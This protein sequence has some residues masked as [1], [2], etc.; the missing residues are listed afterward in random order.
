MLPLFY[1]VRRKYRRL[2]LRLLTYMESL[3]PDTA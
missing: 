3:S 2:G 1:H